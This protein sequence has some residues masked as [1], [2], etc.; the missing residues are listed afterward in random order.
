VYA[1]PLFIGTSVA[2]TPL[3]PFAL[4]GNEM[5]IKLAIAICGMALSFNSFAF[6]VPGIGLYVFTLAENS[7]RA[8]ETAKYRGLEPQGNVFEARGQIYQFIQNSES[9]SE[10]CM[11]LVRREFPKVKTEHV[12]MELDRNLLGMTNCRAVVSRDFE[13]ED[14]KIYTYTIGP[15]GKLI[16]TVTD[17]PV[18]V[19]QKP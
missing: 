19:E 11:N 13:V 12:Y 8:E 15:D 4:W 7:G 1:P 16:E 17:K 10:F 3:N 9:A 2:T 18:Q 14:G 6:L 5:K